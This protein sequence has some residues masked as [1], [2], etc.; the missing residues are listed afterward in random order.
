MLFFSGAGGNPIGF[1]RST[2]AC[3]KNLSFDLPLSS[4]MS[5]LLLAD[6]RDA[7]PGQFVFLS[8][9]LD[10]MKRQALLDLNWKPWDSTQILT[11]KPKPNT[12]CLPHAAE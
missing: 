2:R 5:C 10:K 11:P 6:T 3:H 1:D 9:A 12:I 8:V 7:C 4:A